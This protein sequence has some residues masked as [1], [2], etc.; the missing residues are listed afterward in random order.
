MQHIGYDRLKVSYQQAYIWNPVV[1]MFYISNTCLT[2]C[3]CILS[4]H[5]FDIS[6]DISSSLFD[7]ALY[8]GCIFLSQWH[9][10]DPNRWNH[11][12]MATDDD[13]CVGH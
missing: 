2:I 6:M 3:G 1:I 10:A 7:V 5:L 12:S 8:T 4:T 11:M 9:I 13:E